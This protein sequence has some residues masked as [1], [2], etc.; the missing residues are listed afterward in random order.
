MIYSLQEMAIIS[1][2]G[3]QERTNFLEVQANDIMER[4]SDA[5]QFNCGDGVDTVLDY[6]DAQGD[7]L[8][9]NCEIVNE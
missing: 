8:S 1:Y 3:G 4:G 6:N 9:S 5:D 7:L 2:L